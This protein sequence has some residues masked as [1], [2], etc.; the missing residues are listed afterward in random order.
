MN[1]PRQL[2]LIRHA[3]SLRNQ[4]K[5][6][7]IYF[8]DNDTRRSIAGIPDHEIPL[9]DR[10]REQ[11]RQTGH[12]LRECYGVFD[13][14]YHSGYKRTIDTTTHLLE[15]YSEEERQAIQVRQNSFIRERD[16]GYAYDMTTEE[17][18]NAFPWLK[19]YWQT[20]GGFM[21]RPPG[22]ESLA[23][24]ANRVYTFIGS[25][26]RDRVGQN[27]AVVTHGGT[28]RCFRYLLERWD[29]DQAT[30]WNGEQNPENCGTTVYQY[31]DELGRLVLRSYNE[32][33]WSVD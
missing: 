4:V 10:G 15:A 20:F 27:V 13:Y 17:A 18:E 22:G 1:R 33:H 32:V 5:K 21:A 30:T 3:E 8:T 28:L 29:Y 25:L 9:T 16:P 19:E 6:G 26:F 2:V 23:D 11:A 14:L 12:A 7:N 24:T 31:D